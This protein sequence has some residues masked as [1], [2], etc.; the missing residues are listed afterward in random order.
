MSDSQK[1]VRLRRLVANIAQLPAE[2][3]TA[4]LGSLEDSERISVSPLFEEY[5]HGTDSPAA[6][7]E[8][9]KGGKTKGHFA[10]RPEGS[11][12]EWLMTLAETLQSGNMIEPGNILKRDGSTRGPEMTM[13]TKAAIAEILDDLYPGWRARASSHKGPVWRLLARLIPGLGRK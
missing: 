1:D 8:S 6:F 7:E 4:I 13:A 2:E 9:V 3:I 12:P 11:Q 10:T 5:L